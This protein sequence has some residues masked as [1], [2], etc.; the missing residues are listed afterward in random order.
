MKIERR[1]DLTAREWAAITSARPVVRRVLDRGQSRRAE[2]PHSPGRNGP[3]PV[4]GCG[5]ESAYLDE[6]KKGR[7]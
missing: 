1:K 2:D 6:L 7:A 5:R 4:N 3:G